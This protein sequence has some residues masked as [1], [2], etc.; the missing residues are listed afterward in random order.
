MREVKTEKRQGGV[1][2]CI[3]EERRVLFV[4]SYK[5]LGKLEHCFYSVSPII[6]CFKTTPTPDG[7][8]CL[9]I[10]LNDVSDMVLFAKVK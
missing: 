2:C 5:T 6:I 7:K 1:G 10:F 3:R 9:I 4:N 8:R